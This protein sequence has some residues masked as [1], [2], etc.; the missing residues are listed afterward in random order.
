MSNGGFYK[1]IFD[2]AG[3]E[4]TLMRVQIAVNETPEP[5]MY[6]RI[7]TGKVHKVVRDIQM[8]GSNQDERRNGLF[9]V[10]HLDTMV[11]HIGAKTNW[12]LSVPMGDTNRSLYK[13]CFFSTWFHH[14]PLA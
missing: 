3:W 10:I 6:G 1:R 2:L 5:S 8:D 7:L 12:L 11:E 14:F 9:P 4:F 13:A